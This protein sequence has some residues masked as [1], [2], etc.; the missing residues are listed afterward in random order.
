MSPTVP[1]MTNCADLRSSRRALRAEQATVQWWRRL[2]QARLDLAVAA[3]A[4]PASLGEELAV[5]PMPAGWVEPPSHV[6]LRRATRGGLPLAEA[7]RLPVLRHLDE[8]LADYER[9][10]GA[11]LAEVTEELIEALA[12]DP[13]RLL[14]GPEAPRPI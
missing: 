5:L 11:A 14:A 12:V 9:C 1:T 6:E 3:A 2:V 8:R 10:V 13:A 4:M 7:S